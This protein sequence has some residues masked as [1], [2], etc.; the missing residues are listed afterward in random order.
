[1]LE[2]MLRPCANSQYS[3]PFLTLNEGKQF[4]VETDRVSKPGES[5][6]PPMVRARQLR[7]LVEHY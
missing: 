7:C 2:K 3:K 1:M 6:S 4:L 5:L